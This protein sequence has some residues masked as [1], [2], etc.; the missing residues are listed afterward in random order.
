MAIRFYKTYTP[1][2]RNRSLVSGF[3]EIVRTRP[4]KNL[5][6]GFTFKKGRNNRGI[7]TSRHR[8][9]GHKRL[10]RQIDFRRNKED[11]S[12]KIV[13]I[14]YDPN[15]NAYICL[16]HYEDGEK[17]YIL[18]PRGVKIGDT[19]VSGPKA[20]ISIGNTLPLSAV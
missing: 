18:H 5:T 20:P 14:E 15:R 10:Y 12:G 8:G 19:I 2:T 7:I 13:T 4:E 6:Y 3:E 1:S 17:K 11:I 16:V 9:G